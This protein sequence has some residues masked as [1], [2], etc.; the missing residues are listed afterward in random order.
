MNARAHI[1]VIVALFASTASAVDVTYTVSVQSDVRGRT[2]L[3]GDVGTTITSDLQL[4]PR[5]EV[6]FGWSTTTV[7]LQYT[8]VLLWREPQTGGRLLTLQRGRVGFGH[9]WGRAQLLLTQEGAWGQQDVGALRTDGNPLT[10]V[11]EIQTFGGIPYVRSATFATLDASPSERVRLNLSGGF[12]YQGSP[13]RPDALPLQWGPLVNASLRVGVT[14]VDSLTTAAS[15]MS[16]TFTTT[17]EQAIGQLREVWERQLS[18]T[19]QLNLGAG[20]ALTRMVIIQSLNQA[21]PEGPRC[22]TLVPRTCWDVLPVATAG[23]GWNDRI[24]SM[25]ARFGLSTSLAPFADRFTGNVYERIEARAQAELQPARLWRLRAAGG[26]AYA[27]ALG[28]AAQAGDQFYS[29][30]AAATW[31]AQP[32]LVLQAA[33]R[34]LWTEQPRFGNPGLLQAV[35]SISATVQQ[36]DSTAW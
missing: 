16:S 13:E 15:F 26:M 17:E 22:D 12:T 18:R 8:P 33:G 3:P 19:V 31:T 24:R 25:P 30:E 23:L 28:L 27:T 11:G 32:W 2:P 36:T 6:T 14:R 29:G 4:D 1:V 5:G 21:L 35:V 9:R 7:G 20:L 10:Q 34:V